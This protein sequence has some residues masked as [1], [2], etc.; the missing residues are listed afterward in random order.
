MND[1]T[2][3]SRY[4]DAV[5]ESCGAR[6]ELDSGPEGYDG[7]PIEITGADAHEDDCPQAPALAVE[8]PLHMQV[9]PALN[10][11]EWIAFIPTSTDLAAENLTIGLIYGTS[12]CE[13]A[14]KMLGILDQMGFLAGRTLPIV[15]QED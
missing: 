7:D 15:F 2:I 13:A 10:G 12:R 4:F 14:G 8:Q 1:T 3:R 5:C 6:V 11:R 9:R